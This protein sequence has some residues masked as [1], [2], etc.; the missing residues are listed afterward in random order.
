MIHLYFH[1]TPNPM[2][3]ALFLEETGL[4]YEVVPVDT[5]KG[6]QHAPEF[7]AINPNAKTPAIVDTEGIA[8]LSFSTWRKRQASSWG[9]V[10]RAASCCP[11]LCLWLAGSAHSLANLC[12][13]DAPLRSKFRMRRTAICARLS[14]TTEYLT[15]SSLAEISSWPANTQSPTSRLGAGS[16]GQTSYSARGGLR[17]LAI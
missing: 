9:P 13:F 11:G 6:E 14:G 8:A 4:R 12:I 5:Y 3:V 10:R 7:R 1:H 2:K 15:S 16:I 17:N